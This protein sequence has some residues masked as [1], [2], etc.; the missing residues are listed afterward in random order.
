MIL[1]I[2]KKIEHVASTLEGI[3]HTQEVFTKF[4]ELYPKDWKQ[5]KIEYSK[6]NRSKQFG[7]TIPL[8]KPEQSLKKMISTWLI[9]NKKNG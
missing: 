4:I 3:Y 5:H 7:R 8:P 1:D 9:S 6:F 2:E